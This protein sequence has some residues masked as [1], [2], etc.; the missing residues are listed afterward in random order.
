MKNE[1][2]KLEIEQTEFNVLV[3]RYY[4]WSH[5]EKLAHFPYGYKSDEDNSEVA[6]KKAKDFIDL[7]KLN[8]PKS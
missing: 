7:W 4:S 2:P 1:Y 8:H 5:Y 6:I 3:V